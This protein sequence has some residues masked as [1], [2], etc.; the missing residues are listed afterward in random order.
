MYFSSNLK[1]LRKNNNMSQKDLADALGYSF[2]N[3]SKWE[4][5]ESVPTYDVLIDIGKIFDIDV[6]TLMETNLQEKD[7]LK[8]KINIISNNSIFLNFQKE[9]FK[10]IYTAD[11]TKKIKKVFFYEDDIVFEGY[12]F[13]NNLKVLLKKEKMNISKLKYL[14]NC[15]LDKLKLNG[16]ILYFECEINDNTIIITY[17]CL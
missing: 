14:L 4:L 15:I 11:K 5:G 8:Y 13:P 9:I 12:D 2:R 17:Q 16:Y 7:M 10:F 6:K 1:L 3:I